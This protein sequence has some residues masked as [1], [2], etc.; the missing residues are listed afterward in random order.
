MDISEDL[1]LQDFIQGGPK[2]HALTKEDAAT[3]QA[4]YVVRRN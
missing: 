2:P 1:P 3:A 4:N